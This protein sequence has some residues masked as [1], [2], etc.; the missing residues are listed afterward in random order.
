MA[1]P[2]RT[3]LLLER[4]RP[5]KGPLPK[6]RQRSVSTFAKLGSTRRSA[7][8]RL[9]RRFRDGATPQSREVLRGVS[10]IRRERR[11]NETP[12]LNRP[13]RSRTL[14]GIK[15]LRSMLMKGHRL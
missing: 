7:D 14:L 13:Q 4:A 1:I 10:K 12:I 9:E 8:A 15:S 3:P 11:S 2:E 5:S 6:A